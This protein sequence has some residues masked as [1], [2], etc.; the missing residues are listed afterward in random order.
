MNSFSMESYE[1][2]ILTNSGAKINIK[3]NFFR[4]D[5]SE[6]I[7]FYKLS[8]SEA[9]IKMSFKDFD[10]ILIGK[11][12]FKTFKLNNSKEVNGYFVLSQTP[13]KTLILSSRSDEDEES[14]LVYY[15]FYILDLNNNIIDTLQFDNNKK[16]KSALIRADI[17]LKIDFYFSDCKSLINRISLFDNTST[18][19]LNLDI[20]GFFDSPV[21]IEC[22]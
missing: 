17:F 5:S 18:Q 13:S 22:L 21:Y 7:I 12:K 1:S 14:N 11:N 20:L 16:A 15:V 10:Y 9:E 4:I 2:F 6:K 8:N 3:P 19:N